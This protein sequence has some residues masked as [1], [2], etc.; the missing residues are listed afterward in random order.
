MTQVVIEF[1]GKQHLVAEGDKL[2]VTV[3]TDVT[4]DTVSVD[5][6]LLLIDGDKTLVGQPYLKGVSVDLKLD[7]VAKGEKIRISRFRAKSRHRRVIG[8][9]PVLSHFVVAKINT[10]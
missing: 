9:R 10:K 5:E 7:K 2:A 3:A 6:V 8:F 1:A 4:K